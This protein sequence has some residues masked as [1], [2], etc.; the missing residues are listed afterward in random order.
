[1]TYVQIIHCNIICKRLQTI[2]LSVRSWGNKAPD[3]LIEEYYVAVK[4]GAVLNLTVTG[5]PLKN[6]HG[7][8]PEMD[9]GGTRMWRKQ[10]CRG[11]NKTVALTK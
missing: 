8:I 7:N 11:E 4:K 10:N 9:E 1:M 5:Y 6:P 3:S 2:Y